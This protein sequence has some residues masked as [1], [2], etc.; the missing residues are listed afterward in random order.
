MVGFEQWRFYRTSTGATPSR[1]ELA[2]FPTD[3]RAEMAQLMKRLQRE[4]VEGLL[5][6]EHE[7]LGKGVFALRLSLAHNEYR[8]YYI[9]DGKYAQILVAVHFLAKNQQK[10]TKRT[11]KTIEKRSSSWRERSKKW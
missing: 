3:A 5:P 11:A 7:S 9:T 1:D 2:A 10:I 8:C 4:G 6:R